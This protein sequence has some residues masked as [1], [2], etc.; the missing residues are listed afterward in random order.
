MNL[1][2]ATDQ[3]VYPTNLKILKQ[4]A[5]N[6]GST[7]YFAL[8]NIYNLQSAIWLLENCKKLDGVEYDP[9]INFRAIL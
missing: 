9:L 3:T 1:R 8:W 2:K 6:E 4:L 5:H 7:S